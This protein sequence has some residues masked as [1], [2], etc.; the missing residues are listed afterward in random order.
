[1]EE[2]S[3]LSFVLWKEQFGYYEGLGSEVWPHLQ[4]DHE[5]Q[6]SVLSWSS[7]PDFFFFKWN[8]TESREDVTNGKCERGGRGGAVVTEATEDSGRGKVRLEQQRAR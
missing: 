6:I 4:P 5:H 3:G 8:G 1:M 7:R 2:S